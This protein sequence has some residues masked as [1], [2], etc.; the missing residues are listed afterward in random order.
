MMSGSGSQPRPGPSGTLTLPSFA[1][2]RSWNGLASR[3]MNSRSNGTSGAIAALTCNDAR[4]PGAEIRVVRHDAD[5]VRLRQ[6]GDLQHRGGAA[7]LD[8]AGLCDVDRAGLELGV[9]VVQAGGILAG[10]DRDAALAAHARETS[11]IARRRYRFLQ[12]GQVAVA[13]AVRHVDR[14]PH[15]PGA[16]GVHH[17]ARVG[18]DRLARGAHL[19]HGDLVQLDV[20]IAARGGAFAG[21]GDH[22]CLA[23]A[24]QAGIGGEMGDGRRAEHPPQ[25]QVGGLAGDVPQRDVERRQG[26]HMRAVAAEAVERLRQACAQAA[27]VAR[28]LAEDRGGKLGIQRGLGGGGGGVAERLAP[29]FQA[30]VGDDAQPDR[31]HRLPVQAADLCGLAAHVEWDAR[32]VGL[33]RGDL[34]G[35]VSPGWAHPALVGMAR[36]VRPVRRSSDVC[37]VTSRSTSIAAQIATIPTDPMA[38]LTSVLRHGRQRPA[39]TAFVVANGKDVDADLR[40]NDVGLPPRSVSVSGYWYWISGVSPA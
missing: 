24:Q 28:V 17:Q 18:A 23:V 39:S 4:K 13:H 37:A 22:G 26:E 29:A 32:P 34:H 19:R 30:L 40:R 16:V 31:V 38:L 15:R 7:D 11:M 35:V 36:P 8:H 5:A 25:R 6:R 10:G 33:D 12:P 3:S 20:A 21:G 27:D 1:T 9:E 14:L 2:T